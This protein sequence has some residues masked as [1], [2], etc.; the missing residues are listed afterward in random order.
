MKDGDCAGLI[1][2]QNHYGYVGVQA[3][4]SSKSIV[5]VSEDGSGPV[6]ISKVPL[7]QDRVSIRIEL[8]FK[9]GA[10]TA[11]FFYSLDGK[12]WNSIGSPHHL[13]YD[14]VHFMGCRFGLFNYATKYSGGY[15]DFDSFHISDHTSKSL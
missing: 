11:T 8:D 3:E 7:S 14:L 2:L 6:V 9:K 13:R 4:G 10:D 15:V 1:A 12:L 5:V